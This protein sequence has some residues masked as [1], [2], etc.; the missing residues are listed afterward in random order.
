M[1]RHHLN[2]LSPP[3]RVEFNRQLKDAVEVGLV[4]PNHNNEFCWI[5]KYMVTYRVVPVPHG[6][7]VWRQEK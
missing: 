3:E 1:K 2:T 7:R 5:W 4:R 6:G